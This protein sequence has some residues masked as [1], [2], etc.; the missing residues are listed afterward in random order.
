MFVHFVDLLNLQQPMQ[1]SLNSPKDVT[2]IRIIPEAKAE[3]Y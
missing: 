3:S 1:Y 2:K